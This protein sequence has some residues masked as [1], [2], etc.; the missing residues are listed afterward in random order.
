MQFLGGLVFL[1]DGSNTR[2]TILRLALG[3][4]VWKIGY[5]PVP[6]GQ[7][8]RI[9]ERVIGLPAYRGVVSNSRYA[10]G[11]P[12][13]ACRS[14]RRGHLKGRRTEALNGLF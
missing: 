5:K 11:S 2:D 13:G 3:V 10:D 6:H 9:K 4:W 8:R 7:R 14:K 12:E 1:R